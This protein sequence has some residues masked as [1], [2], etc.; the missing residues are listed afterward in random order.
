MKKLYVTAVVAGAMFFSVESA[1]AQVYENSQAEAEMQQT[2]QTDYTQIE[3]QDLPEEVRLAVARDYQGST[4]SEIYSRERD[5]QT[6][7]KL[8]LSAEDGESQ[9]LF[10]DAQGNWIENDEQDQE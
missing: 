3:E 9:E 2:Q 7:Y 4:L 5:G 10:A 8:V 6:T 1:T